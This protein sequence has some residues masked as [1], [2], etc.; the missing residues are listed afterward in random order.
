MLD[1]E[2]GGDDDRR[3]GRDRL[4]V[5]D[6][7]DRDP[8]RDPRFFGEQD[9]AQ[10]VEDAA[11]DVAR[12]QRLPPGDLGA[13]EPEPV[14]EE[15]QGEVPAIGAEDEEERQDHD[16]RDQPA[17][18]EMDTL[19]LD[20]RPL[21]DDRE[22]EEPEDQQG[23]TDL[24]GEPDFAAARGLPPELRSS[25]AYSVKEWLAALHV[26]SHLSVWNSRVMG[27]F[28]LLA[29]LRE[30]LPQA[31]PRVKLG[32]GDDAAVTVPGGATATSVD[33]IV[34]GVH[35]RRRGGRARR[36][37]VARRSPPPSPT[38]RRWGRSRARPTSSSERRRILA[39]RTSS[40]CSTA[41]SASPPRPG[42]PSPAATSPA[43]RH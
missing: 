2:V 37:S 1:D 28:E 25:L 24:E 22:D 9:P 12:Q 29:K 39:R 15:A 11:G 43:P 17:D 8:A 21:V 42:P 38:W 31:G 32:S 5:D 13:A 7:G 30:R 6:A 34:D 3:G 33:A 40:P 20:L 10:H 14:A 23:E 26:R 36:R 16:R 35:F 18:V 19:V 4:F 27:E 41:C